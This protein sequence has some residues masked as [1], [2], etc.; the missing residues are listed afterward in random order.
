M[1]KY[2]LS[3]IFKGSFPI[4]QRYGENPASYP[5]FVVPGHEGIDWAMPNGTELVA[6]FNG[7]VLRDTMLDKDYGNF[8]VVWDPVQRCAVWYCHL[9]S[10]PVS[11]GDKVIKGQVVAL[12]NNTGRS[13][14]PHLHA[15]FVETDAVGNRL[16]MNNGKQG[17]L[18][19]LDPN[20]V[21]WKLG[22]SAVITQPIP[23]QAQITPQTRLPLFDNKE[24]QQVKAEYEAKD[25]R[26]KDL[27]NGIKKVQED[28]AKLV[29]EFDEFKKT[30]PEPAFQPQSELGKLLY[31]AAR[32][33]G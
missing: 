23:Q 18:N 2:I 16:N 8:L 17:F 9:K 13:T 11:T 27:E 21:E 26:I 4:T 30:I 25:T 6:P 28:A 12:S 5:M 19:I 1:S 22:D 14:G 33:L 3:D 10:T 29:L 24:Q 32:K 20:L 15:N 7:V 31:A